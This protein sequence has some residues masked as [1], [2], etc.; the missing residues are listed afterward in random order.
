V[1]ILVNTLGASSI[2][3][4]VE[5]VDTVSFNSFSFLKAEVTVLFDFPPKLDKGVGSRTAGI[6]C[7]S[8]NLASNFESS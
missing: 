3:L 7:G 5:C 4:K 2:E 8:F 1:S 6:F